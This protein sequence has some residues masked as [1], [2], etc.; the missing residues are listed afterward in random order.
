VTSGPTLRDLLAAHDVPCDGCRYNLR[1]QTGETCPECGRPI[2]IER[3]RGVIEARAWRERRMPGDKLVMA[4]LVGSL[5]GL[6]YAAGAAGT[7]VRVM[8]SGLATPVRLV[9]EFTLW[10]LVVAYPLLAWTY[11]TRTSWIER[12]SRRAKLALA[13]AAWGL[14]PMDAVLVALLILLVR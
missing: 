7:L 3:V 12:R 6:G 8:M 9:L 4:G 2:K 10:P 13:I 11:L 14:G 5:L 1:G